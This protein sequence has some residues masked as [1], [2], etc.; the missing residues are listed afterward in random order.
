MIEPYP[1]IPTLLLVG[2]KCSGKSL[3][4]EGIA[5]RMGREGLRAT[6]F[7]QRGVFDGGGVKIGYDLVRLTDGDKRPLARRASGGKGWTFFDDVFLFAKESIKGDADACFIDE[8]GPVEIAG[9][10]H[11]H[12]LTSSLE[13]SW[14]LMVVVRE[15]LEDEVLDIIDRHRDVR[16]IRHSPK[17][18]RE[19]EDLIMTVIVETALRRRS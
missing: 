7:V 8:I 13:G 11:R 17:T 2:P 4:V 15:E 14:L 6:G 19:N 16:T 1:M 10:G 5:A 18:V 9:K 3:L 12:T